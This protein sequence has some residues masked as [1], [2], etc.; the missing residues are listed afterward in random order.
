MISTIFH[1]VVLHHCYLIFHMVVSHP[2]YWILHKA[3]GLIL[4]LGGTMSPLVTIG[5]VCLAI[6][7]Y[8]CI[9]NVMFNMLQKCTENNKG[10]NR[11]NCRH[12]CDIIPTS[13]HLGDL[14]LNGTELHHMVLNTKWVFSWTWYA[15]NSL[16]RPE[17]LTNF[18]YDIGRRAQIYIEIRTK[19]KQGKSE[20]FESCDRPI[21]R[22]RPIW[23]KIGDV[24]YRVTLKFDGWP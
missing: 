9:Q 22:K 18:V 16:D 11:M 10:K 6:C 15:A 19:T 2:H 14:V 13:Y 21:V 12:D 5:R 8:G 23:V 20:G 7:L 1:I 4:S 24:L 17:Q 3:H